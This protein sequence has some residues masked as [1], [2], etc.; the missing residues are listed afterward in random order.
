[1]KTHQEIRDAIQCVE[2][3][4]SEDT[5]GQIIAILHALNDRIEALD[6]SHKKLALLQECQSRTIASLCDIHP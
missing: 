6:D 2:L 3:L 4:P 5:N 1:M